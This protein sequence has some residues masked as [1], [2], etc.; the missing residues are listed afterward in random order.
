M[1]TPQDLAFCQQALTSVTNCYGRLVARDASGYVVNSG[2]AT[3][4][5]LDGRCILD[6]A[7]HVATT[8][9]AMGGVS[10]QLFSDSSPKPSAILRPPIEIPLDFTNLLPMSQGAKLDVAAILPPPELLA[11]G[12]RK[13]EVGNSAG[14]RTI[15][16][17]AAI[18][19]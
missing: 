4:L 16:N 7:R 6:T 10:L 9:P 13:R 18:R 12:S 8:L 2:T 1:L 14:S 17:H 5:K 11:C 3:F 19:S 15:V